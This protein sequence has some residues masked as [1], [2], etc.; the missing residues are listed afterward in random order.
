VTASS[1]SRH[2]HL[3]LPDSVRAC[4]FDLDGV[5]TRTDRV[6]RAGALRDRGADVA[7]GDL[8]ELL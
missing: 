8:A 6:G 2:R 3:G 4:L 1:A 5:L 7:V